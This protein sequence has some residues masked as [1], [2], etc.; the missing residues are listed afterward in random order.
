MRYAL[1]YSLQLSV[2]LQEAAGNREFAQPPIADECLAD[3]LKVILR[4]EG[5]RLGRTGEQKSSANHSTT[6]QA[7]CFSHRRERPHKAVVN[8]RPLS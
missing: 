7:A 2:A 3:L 6:A 8:G 5:K 4:T 1:R